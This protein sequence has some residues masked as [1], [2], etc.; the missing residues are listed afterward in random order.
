RHTPLRR[1]PRMAL[2]EPDA[3]VPSQ[4]RFLA[5][6]RAQRLRPLVVVQRFQDPARGVA[7]MPAVPDLR[8]PPPLADQA[9]VV[10]PLVLL[11][12]LAEHG[13]RI[14]GPFSGAAPELVRGG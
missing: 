4:H 1:Q 3:V 5:F 8:L 6:R 13:A 7:R 2:E 11:A 10:L 14:T 12:Q 9:A